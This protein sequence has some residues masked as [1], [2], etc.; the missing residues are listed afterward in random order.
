MKIP[1][2]DIDFSNRNDAL[3]LLEYTPA[4]TRTQQGVRPHV[5]VYFQNIPT[6][7][8]TGNCAFDYKQAEEHGY[9]KIDFLNLNIYQQVRDRSHLKKLVNMEPL[10]ELLSS[11]DFVEQ[12]FHLKGHTELVSKMKPTNIEQLAMLLA[13]IR[14]GKEHLIGMTWDQIEKD[15]WSKTEEGYTF[16]KAHALSYALV[17]VVQMNLLVDQ[18]SEDNSE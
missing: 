2:I 18:L 11:P 9:I 14:P 15:I 10:W 13:L 5:G 17:V 6:N 7:P 1:D 16:K 8:L 4:I 3:S 12:L